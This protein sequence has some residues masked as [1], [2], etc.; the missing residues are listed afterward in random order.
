MDS[1]GRTLGELQR[2]G[3]R[4]NLRGLRMSP[5]DFFLMQGMGAL[6]LDPT[7]PED[8]TSRFPV[9]P[10]KGLL[11]G[12][13]GLAPPGVMGAVPGLVA[14]GQKTQVQLADNQAKLAGQVGQLQARQKIADQAAQQAARAINTNGRSGNLRGRP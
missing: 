12:S 3:L 13:R 9:A 14:A 8:Q 4:Q 6:G 7:A 11:D 5:A 1:M 2:G 10:G